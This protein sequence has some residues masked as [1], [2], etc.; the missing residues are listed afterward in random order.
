MVVSSKKITGIR[1]VKAG[2]RPDFDIDVNIEF[3]KDLTEHHL[4]EVYGVGTTS[5]INTFGKMLAKGALKAEATIYKVPY[6]EANETTK[7]MPDPVEGKQMSLDNIFDTEHPR[8]NE[9]QDFRTR[10]SSSVWKEPLQG[11]RAIE[12][13]VKN[14][15]I[16]A[17]GILMSSEKLD[18]VVPMK[19]EF[20]KEQKEW[21]YVSQWSFPECE[22]LGLVKMDFLGLETLDLHMK[23]VRHIIA[24]GKTPPSI[25]ELLD[26]EMNDEE[27]FKLFRSGNTVGV[28]QFVSDGAMDLLRRSQPTNIGDLGALTAL[29]RPGPMDVSAHLLFADRK[30][31]RVD[32]GVP[33]HKDF[34][35]S[36]L[37]DILRETYNVIVYQEQVMSI[38]NQISGMT[39]QEGDD[40]RRAMG[41]KK[42]AVM[43]SMKD[44]FIGGGMK[45]GY[46]LDA[47]NLLWD[48]IEGFASYAFNKCVH[49]R[50]RVATDDG[51]I[52]VE[53]L[54]EKFESNPQEPIYIQSMFEDGS[55]RLNRVRNVVKTGRKPLYTVKTESGKR[56]RITIDHRMLTPDGYKTIGDGG[57][58]V[59]TELIEDA[60]WNKRLSSKARQARSLNMTKVNKS[61][62]N[63]ERA[64]K[65]M[66]EY[67]S[68][69]SFED[70][71]NH[72][73]QIL[74]NNPNKNDKAVR[75]MHKALEDLRNDPQWMNMF[76]DSCEETRRIK[77]ESGEY[78][79]FGKQ[80]VL[81]NGAVCDSIVE[82]LAG[83]YF[84]D[85]GVDFETHKRFAS[86]TTGR[87]KV[88][89]FYADGLYFEMDGLSR[90]R[91]Y[92]KETKYGN[93]IP[94][95]YLTPENYKE[96]I[97][98]ALSSRYIE[99]G[100]RIVA[101][102]A[103][104]VAKNG[105]YYTE[106]SYDIEM[107][108]NGPSNFIADGLV[109]HNS[110]S[111][112]YVFLS[113][114][115]A[116]LKTHFPV[117]FMAALLSQH[118]S[119]AEKRTETIKEFRR[120]GISL[121]TVDINGSQVAVAPDTKN[122]S[123]YDV[124]YG[125]NGVKSMSDESA[126]I[127]VEERE[128]NGD[129]TSLD[130]MITRCFKR[131]L[132][133]KSAYESLA[134]AGAF[135]NLGVN[136]RT[137]YE[138]VAGILSK[139]KKDTGLED[140]DSLFDMFDD[141]GDSQIDDVFTKNVPEY[142]WAEKL[143]LER[144][145][146]GMYLTG[147]PMD[148]LTES[149]MK[150]LGDSSIEELRSF[151]DQSPEEMFSDSYKSSRFFD[152][153]AVATEIKEKSGSR[154]R[155]VNVTLDDK[156]AYLNLSVSKDL[157]KRMDKWRAQEQIKNAY[158]KGSHDISDELI[159][160]YR[161][162]DA[163]PLPDMNTTTVYRLRIKVSKSNTDRIFTS[164]IAVTPVV[165][166]RNGQ[167]P[168]RLRFK[169][170]SDK[171]K[172]DTVRQRLSKFPVAL[173]DKCPGD[174]PIL[175]APYGTSNNIILAKSI[176]MVP[177][178]MISDAVKD[179]LESDSKSPEKERQWPPRRREHAK[180]YGL[181]LDGPIETDYTDYMS[182]EDTGYTASNGDDFNMVCQEEMESFYDYD[183][184][185]LTKRR[186]E[187]N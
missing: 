22:A 49:G 170:P 128:A 95:V 182:Y 24:N 46:S 1:T 74:L 28:F 146:M 6:D 38:S 130:N 164:I 108:L 187:D 144:S 165:L 160:S 89:D 106:M 9:A 114:A 134:L 14:T 40:F 102:E 142:A 84:I 172:F 50:T 88:C 12:G 55:I 186:L 123:K 184:G 30:A 139:A 80:V 178:Q 86:A 166:A 27:T 81:S 162:N 119:K 8:Y 185:R 76:L 70:R 72:Q 143:G 60:D 117:E 15:G 112:A 43:E 54:Y 62:A 150:R 111:V 10:V 98:R 168:I 129:F 51:K 153:V 140:L 73:K 147:H 42:R 41:K 34:V 59:G 20:D 109:S 4:E 52:T 99:N 151:L 85:L 78:K 169:Y 25:P 61:E 138:S 68:A 63:R 16:H 45:N 65:H 32:I 157:I 19:Y 133:N 87:L 167:L 5:H 29:Y 77:S 126:R 131:G 113:Y 171:T 31:G 180:F 2:S 66:K 136:R 118:I 100:D 163:L 94:F 91:E 47:M 92:F 149:D 69:L 53:K 120:L 101:I 104:K 154:G 177:E 36:P 152:V 83:E 116:Y 110:H 75:S 127:I 96:E 175:V 115:S 103:P 82:A 21:Q 156:S 141:G 148:K 58:S 161:K 13:R 17:C 7:L 124:I 105:N 79:G 158:I 37:E 3:R 173:S 155:I 33:I 71:S 107:D 135:D 174:V 159:Q 183:A 11:A 23:T 56:I 137:A 64:R 35:G 125:L 145:M 181:P 132:N 97:D 67:Q 44:K 90:G 122:V 18:E 179:I 176:N 48:T 57:I 26:G 39:L 93:E 121:G